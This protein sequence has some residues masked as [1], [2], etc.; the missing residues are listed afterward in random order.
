MAKITWG[1][2]RSITSV[3]NAKAWIQALH[4]N[5]I[6]CGLVQTSDT[7]QLDIAGIA[8]LPAAGAFFGSLLYKFSDSLATSKPVIIKFQPGIGSFGGANSPMLQAQVG[9]ATDGAGAITGVNSAVFNAFNNGGGNQRAEVTTE[10]PSYAV[11]GEGYFGLCLNLNSFSSSINAFCSIYLTVMRTQNS[12][13][14]PTTDGVSIARNAAGYDS[15]STVA[16]NIAPRAMKALLTT[17][18]STWRQDMQAWIGGAD[19]ASYL[20]NTQLQRAYRLAPALV[21]DPSMAL[22]WATSIV[23]GDEFDLTIDGITRHY[24]ALGIN[25]GMIADTLN[26]RSVGF[27]MLWGDL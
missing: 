13:G 25:H 20:G 10:T 22:Y 9:F 3:A 27:A 19:A 4:N 23:T 12:S 26:W 24:I 2:L 7:G 18:M 1:S 11:H 15:G 5:L 6:A 16:G 17:S 8:A 14:V 21:P